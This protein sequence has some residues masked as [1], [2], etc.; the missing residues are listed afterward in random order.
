MLCEFYKLGMLHAFEKHAIIGE[1]L[2]TGPGAI[3]KSIARRKAIGGAKGEMREALGLEAPEWRR[4]GILELP[5]L[6]ATRTREA[7]INAMKPKPEEPSPPVTE[8]QP[9]PEP[10]PEKPK[11]KEVELK[12]PKPK[13]PKPKKK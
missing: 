11:T 4:G 5:S 2:R 7:I 9:E 10:K 12:L 3:A 6:A 1:F 8:P 13:I